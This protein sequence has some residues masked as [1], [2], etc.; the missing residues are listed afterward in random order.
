MSANNKMVAFGTVRG[1]KDVKDQQGNVIEVVDTVKSYDVLGGKIWSGFKVRVEDSEAVTNPKNGSSWN[2]FVANF[3][4]K[5][6]SEA[7]AMQLIALEKQEA[8]LVGYL[9]AEN[10]TPKKDDATWV[11]FFYV[12]EVQGSEAPE[13]F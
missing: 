4:V 8:T 9:K 12:T 7:V 2:P 5:T 11:T 3:S 1:T 13:V 6:N 10:V